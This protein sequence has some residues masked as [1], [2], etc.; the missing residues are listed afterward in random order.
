MRAVLG[1]LALVLHRGLRV[2]SELV[3]DVGLSLLVDGF[4]GHH[5]GARFQLGVLVSLVRQDLAILQ[6][7][8]RLRPSDDCAVILKVLQSLV[9]ENHLIPIERPLNRLE[10]IVFP[11]E[12][13]CSE[14]RVRLTDLEHYHVA[15]FLLVHARELL[16][17]AAD[18]VEGA[19]A[20]YPLDHAALRAETICALGVF[21]IGA[22]FTEIA[23]CQL[24]ISRRQLN[25]LFRGHLLK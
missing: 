15:H 19:F 10:P 8:R 22:F 13:I 2:L 20:A 17:V 18:V 9:H 21:E 14:T 3:F 23:R 6:A 16:H 1:V 12:Q 7:L 24:T 5:L 11:L 4:V 25:F